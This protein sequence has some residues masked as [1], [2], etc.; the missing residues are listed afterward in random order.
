MTEQLSKERIKALQDVNILCSVL[1]DQN[2]DLGYRAAILD[3]KKTIHALI[4]DEVVNVLPVNQAYTVTRRKNVIIEVM[5][6]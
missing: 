6:K 2:G 5:K 1:Y 4:S 3:I